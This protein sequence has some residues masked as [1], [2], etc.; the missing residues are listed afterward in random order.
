MEWS[1][2]NLIKPHI[3][4][5]HSVSYSKMSKAAYLKYSLKYIWDIQQ[6]SVLQRTAHSPQLQ[7]LSL[8]TQ[9]DQVGEGQQAAIQNRP[10]RNSLF[11]AASH[12]LPLHLLSQQPERAATSPAT[13]QRAAMAR[14]HTQAVEETG[15][16]I[17][18][19]WILDK[20]QSPGC[21][22]TSPRTSG[23]LLW[24]AI[25][26]HSL[27]LVVL[28]SHIWESSAAAYLRKQT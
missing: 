27:L 11:P 4:W 2:T 8:R 7:Q 1:T 16:G 28:L 5:K 24:T 3:A 25:N 6:N 26:N 13:L 18:N 10:K 14:S 12:T 17:R 19:E 9:W 22:T 23:W 15:V 20:H 21:Q